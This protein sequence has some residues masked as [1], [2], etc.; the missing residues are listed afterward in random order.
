MDENDIS[1]VISN[2]VKL[3]G[4]TLFAPGTS[5]LLQGKVIGGS[6]HVII[7]LAARSLLGP[8]GWLAVTANSYASATTGKNLLQQATQA[9]E[10]IRPVTTPTSTT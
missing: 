9:L 6:L 1:Q 10:A 8:V 7:G 5:L 3:A 4:E 2:G